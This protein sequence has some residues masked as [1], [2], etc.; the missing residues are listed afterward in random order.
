MKETTMKSVRSILFVA[1]LSLSAMAF[2]Q[3]EKHEHGTRQQSAAPQTSK[4]ET[5]K[6]A[7]P[8][9]PAQTS[10]E[11]L[12]SLAG[13]WEGPVTLN[14]PMKGM[15]NTNLHLTM[16]VTSRGNAIAHEF[17]EAGTPFDP[18]KYDHP[19][20]MFY[21]DDNQL[22]LVHYCDAGNRPHMTGKASQDGKTVEFDLANLSGGNEK[23]HMHRAAFTFIDE[24]HH[25][26]EWTYM[27]PGDKPMKARMDLRRVTTS[28]AK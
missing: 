7:A 14:P 4:A 5:A 11:S 8:K 26:E 19:M 18:A 24:N 17:Q 2:A 16:R 1:L 9:S 15:G 20:T 27:L 28:A 13:E 10:F 12:K 22:N 21:V 3:S 25:I 23:G 6:P